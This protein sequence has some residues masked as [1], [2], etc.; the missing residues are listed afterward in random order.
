VPVQGYDEELRSEQEYIAGLYVRL[1]AERA[2]VTA[3]YD[4]ALLGTGGTPMERDVSVRAAAK[5][6]RRL[7][8]ADTGLCFGRLDSLAGERSYIGRIGI[9][10]EEDDYRIEGVINGDTVTDVLRYVR[11]NRDE[12]VAKVRQATEAALK[13]K[14]MTFEES[15]TL[16]RR[17]EE[18]LAGYTYLEQD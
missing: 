16:L 12:L 17:Y 18:G 1:D 13:A 4:A 8:V 5:Q 10:D 6:M 7:D 11:Y 9:L 15:K 14:R 2:R 3:E